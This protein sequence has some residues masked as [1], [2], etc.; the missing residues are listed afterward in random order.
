[1][2]ELIIQIISGV[3]AAM[4][5][6]WFGIGK[7]KTT[8]IQT[9]GIKVNK[10]GK[11]MMIIGVIMVI[12]GIILFGSIDHSLAGAKNPNEFYFLALMVFGGLIFAIGKFINWFQ[13]L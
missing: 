1:M 13:K 8:V 11:W 9:Q 7:N 10:T 3:I 12:W 5:I 2:S 4:L 6:A